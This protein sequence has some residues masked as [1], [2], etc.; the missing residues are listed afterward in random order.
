MVSAPFSF[1]GNGGLLPAAERLEND[2]RLHRARGS[3]GDEKLELMIVF[4]AH[5][6]RCLM[7]DGISFPHQGEICLFCENFPL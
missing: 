2:P 6:I 4:F 1:G 3:G 7:T 5:A